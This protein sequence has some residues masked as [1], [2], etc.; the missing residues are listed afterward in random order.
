MA[1][2]SKREFI[3]DMT[4]LDTFVLFSGVFDDSGP[5]IWYPII[6]ACASRRRNTTMASIREQVEDL[7]RVVVSL[8]YVLF[9]RPIFVIKRLRTGRTMVKMC[10]VPH[11]CMV[12]ADRDS[13]LH[14][15]DSESE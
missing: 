6:E 9:P 11:V 2:H 1:V 8:Y 10:L 5:H 4:A 15:L 3:H 14:P 12:F 7:G 13:G